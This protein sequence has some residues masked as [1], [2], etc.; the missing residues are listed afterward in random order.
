MAGDAKSMA[1]LGLA[2]PEFSK[3]LS[4]GACFDSSSQQLVERLRS[5]GKADHGLALLE[6]GGGRLEAHVHDLLASVD[7][8]VH[9]GFR[10]T[11]H[12][13]QVLLRREGHSFDSMESAFL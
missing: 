10:K 6:V 9:F 1:Y 3:D 2:S 11:L 13:N 4:D 12:D 5:S 7:D 8:L